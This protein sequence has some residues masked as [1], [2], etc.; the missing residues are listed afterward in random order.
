MCAL[1][2]REQMPII[3]KQ[4]KYVY[5]EDYRSEHIKSCKTCYIASLNISRLVKSLFHIFITEI[6]FTYHAS[7]KRTYVVIKSLDMCSS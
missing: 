7:A 3:H 4:I 5:K 6:R 1:L 2:E